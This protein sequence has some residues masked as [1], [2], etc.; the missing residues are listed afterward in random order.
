[1]QTQR[2]RHEG[3]EWRLD[4][5]YNSKHRILEAFEVAGQSWTQLKGLV[6]TQCLLAAQGVVVAVQDTRHWRS[7][8]HRIKHRMCTP[9]HCTEDSQTAALSLLLHLLLLLLC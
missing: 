9:D 2:K 3:Q 7:S 6:A 1:M 8:K 4:T 5:L